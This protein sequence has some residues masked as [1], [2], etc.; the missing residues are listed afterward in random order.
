[1]EGEAHSV[2]R[3]PNTGRKY[4]E[5]KQGMGHGSRAQLGG[6]THETKLYT[7]RKQASKININNDDDENKHWVT[8]L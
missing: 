8:G 6:I 5:D 7:G 4:S 1:M 3:G 2:E